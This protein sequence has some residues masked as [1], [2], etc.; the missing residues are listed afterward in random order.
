MLTETAYKDVS[1]TIKKELSK[2]SS[3]QSPQRT[4][5]LL[6]RQIENLNLSLQYF[7]LEFYDELV[8]GKAENELSEIKEKIQK[9]TQKVEDFE[10]KMTEI[11][12]QKNNK[13][14]DDENTSKTNQKELL[15]QEQAVNLGDD[16]LEDGKQRLDEINLG[17]RQGNVVLRDV[18]AEI[19]NQNQ[20]LLGIKEEIYQIDSVMKRSKKLIS[21]FSRSYYEDNCI[22]VL[23]IIIML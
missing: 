20:D 5:R 16:F 23:S 7:E 14:K 21:H 19:A 3:K 13:Q 10:V 4:M 15:T 17:V 6:N 22:R 12:Y 1:K 9:M 18:N 8:F 2:K 11:L